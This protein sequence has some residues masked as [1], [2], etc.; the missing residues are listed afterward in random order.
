MTRGS[1]KTT[2]PHVGEAAAAARH[3]RAGP[4][5]GPRAGVGMGALVL[6][7]TRSLELCGGAVRVCV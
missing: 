2:G 4:V 5:E 7:G 6:R 1:V 3:R